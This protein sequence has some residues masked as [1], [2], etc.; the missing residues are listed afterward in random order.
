NP[1]STTPAVAPPP[2]P[3][4]PVPAAPGGKLNAANMPEAWVVQVGAV[5][6]KKKAEAMIAELKLN[7]HPAFST[8][9]HSDKGDT[10]RVFVGPKL[11]KAKANQLRQRIDTD[12]GVKSMVVPFAPR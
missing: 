10:I 5:N 8:V 11:D 4:P 2:K 3:L 7:G 9:T 1:A 6:D 12:M